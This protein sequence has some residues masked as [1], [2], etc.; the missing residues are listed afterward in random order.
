MKAFQML[1]RKKLM[2]AGLVNLT[3]IYLKINVHGKYISAD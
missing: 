3:M 1:L 2:N